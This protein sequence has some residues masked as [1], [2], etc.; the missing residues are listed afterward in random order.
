MGAMQCVAGCCEAGGG[1]VEEVRGRSSMWSCGQRVYSRTSGYGS[2][3]TV[4]IYTYIN[5]KG[6][7]G[8]ESLHWM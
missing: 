5:N 1:D 8:I 2:L 6:V 7:R 4:E 3:E